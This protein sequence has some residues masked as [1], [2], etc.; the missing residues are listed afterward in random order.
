MN[1]L[2]VLTGGPGSGKTSVTEYLEKE[3]F[4]VAGESGREVIR[5]ELEAGGDAL[6]WANAEAF[7]NRMA[8]KDLSNYH[9]F[10]NSE[11]FAFFD[12]GI[13]DTYGYSLLS[14]MSVPTRLINFCEELRYNRTVFIFPPWPEIYENDNERKQTY[15]VAVAT[16]NM[17]AKVYK[18]LK[19]FPVEVP[20]TSIQKRAEFILSFLHTAK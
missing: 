9:E 11:D 7:R 16:Y 3:G 12:R 14:G 2:I 19:Y 8:E 10:Y 17:I 1:K 4:R 6:P 18:N 15:E 5:E 13:V 20:K